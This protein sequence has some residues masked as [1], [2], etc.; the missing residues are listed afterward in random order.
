MAV[1]AEGA[2][3]LSH[4]I[5]HRF[6]HV[7]AF[8]RTYNGGEDPQ[9]LGDAFVAKFDPAGANLLYSTYI[10][11]SSGD[12]TSR[13]ALD[14]S[15]N[16]YLVGSTRSADFPTLGWNEDA[17]V[18][19]VNMFS[20]PERKSIGGG[21][22]VVPWNHLDGEG[23]NS[24]DFWFENDLSPDRFHSFS[25]PALDFDQAGGPFVLLSALARSGRVFVTHLTVDSRGIKGCRARTWCRLVAWR[26]R[27]LR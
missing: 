1:E 24:N 13:L 19:S 26:V 23:V 27:L 21:L 2:E 8:D 20:V 25:H 9:G 17:I 22:L 6:D 12:I 10:G 4:G 3:D 18:I 14:S 5:Q 16:V 15:G 11:G 7:G